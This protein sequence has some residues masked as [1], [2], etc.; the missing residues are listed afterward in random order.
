LKPIADEESIVIEV[1]DTGMGIIP[2]NQTQI[3]ERFRKGNHKRSGYG[4]GLH[5]SRQI[6]QAHRGTIKVESEFGKGSVFTVRLPTT[7]G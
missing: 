1:E 4:L 7:R 2:E 6:V 3:F 5:L